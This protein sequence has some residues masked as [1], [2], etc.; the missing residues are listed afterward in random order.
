MDDN[1]V[2]AEV[3]GTRMTYEQG[4]F[5][6]RELVQLKYVKYDSPIWTYLV[7]GSTCREFH[8]I[9]IFYPVF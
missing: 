3:F 4:Y 2:I 6:K 5:I 8:I 9:I 7:D 1:N